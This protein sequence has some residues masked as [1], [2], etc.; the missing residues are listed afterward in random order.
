MGSNGWINW[1]DC[2]PAALLDVPYAPR[3]R[4][5]QGTKTVKN[6]LDVICAWDIET[7]RVP[8]MEQ[9][10]CYQW[11]LQIG[12]DA[13]TIRGREMWEFR[14]C[15]DRFADAIQKGDTLLLFVHNLSY[16]FCFLRSVFPDIAPGD[17]F[18]LDKRKV[19]KVKLYGGKI[20]LR[21]SYIMTNMS[22]GQFTAKMQVE[23][24]K[25]SGDEFDY[26]KVRYPWDELT[27]RELEY[28]QNDV[29]GLVEAIAVFLKV[30]RLSLYNVVL[31]STGLVRRDVKR[32]MANWSYYGLQAVQ[33][34]PE[35]YIA[36]REA[37]AGGD[38]HANRYFAGVILHNVKSMDKSSAYP[39]ADVNYDFPMGKFKRAPRKTLKWLKARIL[40]HKA[41]LIRVRW[42]GLRLKDEFDP[43]PYI[44]FSKVRGVK[45]RECRLDNGRI[46]EAPRAEMTFTDLDWKIIE[47]QYD[48]DSIEILDLWETH[49][50]PLPDMLRRLIISYYEDKTRLKD[51]EG[52]EVF[53]TKAKNLLNSIY[54]LQAQDPCKDSIIFDEDYT[55]EDGVREIFH[56]EEGDIPALLEKAAKRPYGSYQWGVWTT[57]HA[58]YELRKMITACGDDFVYC[59]TD[60]VKYI[61]ET[62]PE[63]TRYNEDKV[64]QSKRNGAYAKDP[65]GTVH[66][67][68]VFE[69]DGYYER[70]VTLGAKKYAY[71][72]RK[73]L[74]ITVAGVGKKKGAVE[75]EA[76]GGLEAFK[77]AVWER[78]ER[79]RI[80]K[81][82]TGRRVL[83]E[84]IVFRAA[85][86]TEAVYND[87]T[88]LELT[89]DGHMLV[90]GPNL[91]LKPSTYTLGVADDYDEIL[92]STDVVRQIIHERNLKKAL[93]GK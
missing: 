32:V 38:T 88:N 16:E 43:A 5:N 12:P 30:Y 28:C 81:D 29:L 62:P 33:P 61:G 14:A 83:K 80:V 71:E 74:H 22:L 58:R 52:Q 8:G 78:D 86:G 25:L 53:Y 2:N 60:S 45:A 41:L 17:V 44:S 79:G 7:S 1:T 42:T 70:F 9:S 6:V 15:L 75:L 90:I 54:G 40:K 35:V 89:I 24:T 66:Y 84:G 82:K 23:H 26:D 11:Q 57:A 56:T 68:G 34:T 13:P 4:G 20:E 51:V 69:D 31:T 37:F 36:L 18:A 48:W 92:K 19:A 72:D 91:C 27:P 85:G 63:L 3:P 50:G 77:P 21:C 55:A 64:K 76:A 73:G 93:R 59:D 49:Y 67:M 46:M 39:D 87:F 47:A 10:F 65:S